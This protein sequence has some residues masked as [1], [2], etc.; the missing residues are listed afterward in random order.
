MHEKTERGDY[1]EKQYMQLKL[2][3][4]EVDEI[5]NYHVIMF[6]PHGS[7]RMHE[8]LEFYTVMGPTD[9]NPVGNENWYCCQFCR[10]DFLSAPR[11]RQGVIRLPDCPKCDSK[12]YVFKRDA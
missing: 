5:L 11:N 8:N 10:L 7:E 1:V 9:Q 4:I 6:G 3:P 12:Y 2:P